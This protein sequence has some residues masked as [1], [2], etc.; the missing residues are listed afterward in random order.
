M[1]EETVIEGKVM[2]QSDHGTVFKTPDGKF[3]A[4]VPRV[5]KLGPF[6]TVEE[7]QQI[8]EDSDG[9]LDR[10]LENYNIHLT[11]LSD[12]TRGQ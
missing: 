3:V 7:A 6:Q 12:T 8:A 1:W 9:N 10:L 2:W 5:I 4:G 11:K